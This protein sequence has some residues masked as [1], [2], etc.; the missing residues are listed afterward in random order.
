MV[1]GKRTDAS[2]S[3]WIELP[4]T[5]GGL[6]DVA[7]VSDVDQSTRRCDIR[8]F[9]LLRGERLQP[10]DEPGDDSGIRDCY[11]AIPIDIALDQL[12]LHPA[13]HNIG[14]E[15]LPVRVFEG[16]Y[17]TI[18]TPNSS[19]M[20]ISVSV[21]GSTPSTALMVSLT[22]GPSLIPSRP[23]LSAAMKNTKPGVRTSYVSTR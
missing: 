17:S 21:P 3:L 13:R 11:N 20:V 2:D 12:Y 23:G 22:T 7:H 4:E 15:I 19:S 16:I 6:G 10:Q 14:D 9:S 18:S 5:C 8:C 1:G